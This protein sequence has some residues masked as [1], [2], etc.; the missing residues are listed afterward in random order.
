MRYRVRHSTTFSYASAVSVSQNRVCLTPTERRYLKRHRS[1]LR[2]EPEPTTL[3]E[4]VDSFGNTIHVFSMEYAHDALRIDA[5]AEV[6]VSTAELPRL[7]PSVSWERVAEGIR[8]QTDPGW[9]EVQPFLYA[10]PVI[11]LSP[12]AG[13][14][15]GQSLTPGRPVL[16]A[17][18]ALTHQIHEAF[19]YSPGATHVGTDSEEALGLKAGVCQ[20][21][22]HV[23][24]AGLRVLG[25][26]ARYV[27]GYLR[28]VAPPGRP[29]LIGADQ[30]HAWFE[31]YCGSDLGWVAWDP[32]NDVQVATD[33][34]PM[35]IG[36]DYTDV[37]PFRGVFHGGRDSRLSVSV[38]VS[39][40][41]GA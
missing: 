28:T 18:G 40:V 23:A 15:V 26:P 1:V 17:V 22:A 38:D 2:I 13:A 27:S 34:I 19:G 20:D 25:V 32:T 37:A 8:T 9:F 6:T 33:H 12:S 14:F 36:R 30:S 35:A 10:S 21:F 24:I 31:V 11:R 39:P 5:E 3:V 7:T 29:K 16:E 4:R 41:R